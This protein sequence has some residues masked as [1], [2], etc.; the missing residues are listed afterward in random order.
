MQASNLKEGFQQDYKTGLKPGK[1]F[2]IALGTALAVVLADQYTKWLV[3]ETLLRA[4]G[5]APGFLDWFSTA[6]APGYF[7]A[8]QATYRPE[9]LLP[10]LN[11]VMVWNKGISFGMFDENAGAVPAV[12]IAI[13]AV[14]S[15]AL[16][17]W[18][19]LVHRPAVTFATSLIVG[20]AFGNV[21]DRLRFHAVADFIDVHIGERHWPAFNLAD[22]CI[23][24]GACLLVLD[25]LLT[26]DKTR[27][28]AAGG[29][30]ERP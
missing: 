20:G 8:E 25:S 5:E 22:S 12:F 3:L 11:F 2:W 15:A 17:A 14:I 30:S 29:Q 13:S 26:K 6:R 24:A 19:A 23:V 7:E 10:V 27:L 28:P 16:S 1:F 21:A 4:K 9:T 18:A